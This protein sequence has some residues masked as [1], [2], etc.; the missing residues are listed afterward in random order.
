MRIARQPSGAGVVVGWRGRRKIGAPREYLFYTENSDDGNLDA[1][2]HTHDFGELVNVW[3]LGNMPTGYCPV[4]RG[5]E[6][7]KSSVTQLEPAR[8]APICV[9]TVSIAGLC[10]GDCLPSASELGR[11]RGIDD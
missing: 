10:L 1:N 5:G 8:P 9:E 7:C 3:S 11:V 4:R 6:R 2:M